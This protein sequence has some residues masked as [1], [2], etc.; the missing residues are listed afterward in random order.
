LI[1]LPGHAISGPTRERFEMTDGQTG[2]SFGR[3]SDGAEVRAVRLDGHGLSLEVLS[4]GAVI[5][6]LEFEGRPMVLGLDGLADYERRSPHLGAVPGRFANR[7]GGGRLPLDGQT[8]QLTRNESG[9]THL[10]GGDRGFGRRNW[11]ILDA[12]SDAVTL[13]YRSADGEEGYPGALEARC[14]YALAAPATLTITLTATCDRPTVVNLTN[15]SYFNLDGPDPDG[16]WSTADHRLTVPAERCLEVDADK[17]PTGRRLPV[18][19]TTVDF[20]E[21]RAVGTNRTDHALILAEAASPEPRTVAR[22]AG[23]RSGI[24][25]E[26]DSTEPSLQVYDGYMLGDAGLSVGG[27]PIPAGAGLCLEP[28]RFPDA[29][30]HP[31]FPS[32]VLRPGET[33]RHVI[34]YRFARAG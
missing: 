18:A 15:H 27:R 7:I 4:F 34:R 8:Y 11:R 23:A 24:V 21:A 31:D 6:R 28:Q 30:N 32:A 22:L 19:G 2:T 29:P 17:V 9:R 33:Y 12:A 20:R 1:G 26:M 13:A 5:R 3:L 16:T 25:L 10:H 14:T